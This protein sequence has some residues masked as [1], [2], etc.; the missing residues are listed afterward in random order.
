MIQLNEVLNLGLA[1]ALVP[2]IATY[3]R[4]SRV[5]RSTPFTVGFLLILSAYVATIAEG[6][7]FQE[8]LN[9][10]EHLLLAAAG[11][12]YLLGLARMSGLLGR[13]SREHA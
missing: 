12:S 11:F 1:L 4:R 7:F 9:L 13:A 5:K 8:V 6:F 2:L 10:L 3:A